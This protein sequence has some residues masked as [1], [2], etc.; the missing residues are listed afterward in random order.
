[1]DEFERV[2][3]PLGDRN[4]AEDASPSLLERLEDNDFVLK[5]DAFDGQVQCFGDAAPRIVER[6]AE[7]ANLTRHPCCG[8]EEGVSLHGC[9]VQSFS[10]RISDHPHPRETV[11][12]TEI[13]MIYPYVNCRFIDRMF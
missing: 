9:Q 7:G 5:V 4:G 1:M 6:L 8:L 2:Q 13:P 10:R 12:L 3:K 11:L